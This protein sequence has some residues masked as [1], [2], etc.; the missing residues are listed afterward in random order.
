MAFTSVNQEYMKDPITG[1]KVSPITDISTVGLY[2]GNFYSSNYFDYKKTVFAAH[3]SNITINTNETWAHFDFSG[4]TIDI[5]NENLSNN[6]FVDK[7]LNSSNL[8]SAMYEIY[9]SI[10]PEM[11]NGIHEPRELFAGIEVD[12]R[13]MYNEVSSDY[14]FF[15]PQLFDRMRATHK[16]VHTI[17]KGSKINISAGMFGCKDQ[18]GLSEKYTYG[19]IRVVIIRLPKSNHLKGNTSEGTIPAKYVKNSKGNLISPITSSESVYF[20]GS[21]GNTTIKTAKDIG[22]SIAKTVYSTYASVGSATG[23][24]SSINFTGP[25]KTQTKNTIASTTESNIIYSNAYVTHSGNMLGEAIINVSGYYLIES[26]YRLDDVNYMGDYL[27]SVNI[28]GTNHWLSAARS[29]LRRGMYGAK[30]LH[31]NKGDKVSFNFWADAPISSM[32]FFTSII[33][34]LKKD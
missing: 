9:I 5:G 6:Y 3:K 15:F 1:N 21:S 4:W 18:I 19:E 8:S 23:Y 32:S 2:T 26:S 27:E 10:H 30:Y 13:N 24:T 14:G 7:E 31:L 28:N 34:I 25:N 17:S 12:G 29:V 33:T 22:S 20:N 11:L 16:M